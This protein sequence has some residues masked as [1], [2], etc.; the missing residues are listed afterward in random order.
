MA[1]PSPTIAVKVMP[2]RLDLLHA[3]GRSEWLAD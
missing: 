1:G 3:D 2:S